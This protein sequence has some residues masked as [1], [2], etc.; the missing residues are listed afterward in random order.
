MLKNL[1]KEESCL[2]TAYDAHGLL[3]TSGKT[4]VRKVFIN[5]LLH[6]II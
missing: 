2:K 3:S 4:F 6:Y 5:Y 1:I